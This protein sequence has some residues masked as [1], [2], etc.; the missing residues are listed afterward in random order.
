[1]IDFK[2]QANK[3]MTPLPYPKINEVQDYSDKL[4]ESLKDMRI[5]ERKTISALVLFRNNHSE[6]AWKLYLRR[7]SLYETSNL[8]VYYYLTLIQKTLS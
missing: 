7:K 3:S 8:V 2:T 4:S 5:A 1:V 6:W